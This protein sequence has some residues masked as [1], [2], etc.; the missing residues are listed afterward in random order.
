MLDVHID[1]DLPF[2]KQ[3]QAVVLHGI[4][5]GFGL[6]LGVAAGAV[7]LVSVI[8]LVHLFGLK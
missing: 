5:V 1:G 4:C 2:K 6:G 8:K 7:A 3:L